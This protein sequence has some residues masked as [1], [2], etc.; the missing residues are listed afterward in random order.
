MK[1]KRGGQEGG[2]NS[3][4]FIGDLRRN[5]FA[6]GLEFL[7]N[8]SDVLGP[9][10]LRGADDSASRSSL[11]IVV[12]GLATEPEVVLLESCQLEKKY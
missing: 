4:V 1:C 6:G 7:S 9:V 2:K 10:D 3:K 8:P 11:V 12:I 5:R